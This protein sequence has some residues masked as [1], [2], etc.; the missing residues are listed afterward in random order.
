MEVPPK[1]IELGNLAVHMLHDAAQAFLQSDA[2]LAS[3]TLKIEERAN[4]LRS[5]IIAEVEAKG[6]SGAL[7]R[8]AAGA[9]LTVA[10]RLERVADQAKNVCEEVHYMCTGEFPKHRGP[11]FSGFSSW[12]AP[13][14][15]GRTSRGS[16]GQGDAATSV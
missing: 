2:D 14:L 6:A 13:I 15:P 10:R 8:E 11:G 1:A 5:E 16:D 7:S 9:L 3:R 4:E 12:I